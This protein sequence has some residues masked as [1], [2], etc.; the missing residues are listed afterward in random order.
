MHHQVLEDGAE[1]YGM[2]VFDL[3]LREPPPIDPARCWE[4]TTFSV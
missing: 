3:E 2:V 1:P 4:R